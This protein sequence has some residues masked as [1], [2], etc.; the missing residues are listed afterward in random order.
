[1]DKIKIIRF[2]EVESILNSVQI[3]TLA[4]IDNGKPYA[5][6]MN[7]GYIDRT[8]YFHGAPSGRKIDVL[9]MNKTVSAVFYTDAVLNVRHE[10]VACSYSMKFRSVVVNGEI[11]FVTNNDEKI[12]ALNS[13]MQ[14]FSDRTNFTYGLPA[15]NNVN[16]FK[17]PVI[18]YTAYKRGY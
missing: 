4:M 17:L 7:F 8:I 6:S 14:K 10:T 3:C 11:E 16:V 5:V 1:M 12:I 18:D 2:D 9:N 13:V 15:L